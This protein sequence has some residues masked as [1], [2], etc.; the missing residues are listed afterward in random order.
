MVVSS[1]PD[2]RLD[3]ALERLVLCS[4]KRLLRGRAPVGVV[5][6]QGLDRAGFSREKRA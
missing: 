6:I 4:T 3:R 5:V 2:A 1:T